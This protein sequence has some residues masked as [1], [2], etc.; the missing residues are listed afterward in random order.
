VAVAVEEIEEEEDAAEGKASV[1]MEMKRSG[2]IGLGSV[3]ERQRI[4]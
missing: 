2:K 4:W 3:G 1:L